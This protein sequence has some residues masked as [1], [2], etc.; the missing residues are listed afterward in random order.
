MKVFFNFSFCN[1]QK[2]QLFLYIKVL[3]M[4]IWA[5]ESILI[6]LKNSETKISF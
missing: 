1:A 3:R 4:N 6:Q 5:L 2:K